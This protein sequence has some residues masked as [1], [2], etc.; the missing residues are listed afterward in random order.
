MLYTSEKTGRS[1]KT[2]KELDEAEAAF[3]EE[4]R[5]REDEK[6]AKRKKAEAVQE[7]YKAYEAVKRKALDEIDA[8]YKDYAK[9]RDEFA[10]EYGGYHMTYVRNG[11]KE[12]ISFGDI[13]SRMFLW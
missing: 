11:E 10:D 1:Y 9:L 7:A 6:S 12:E 4:Q 13:L 8:A 5:K 2:V 3:D